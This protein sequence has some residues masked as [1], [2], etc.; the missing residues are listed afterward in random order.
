MNIQVETQ[1]NCLTTVRIEL[2]PEKVTQKIDTITRDYHR[3]ARIPGF[4]PGKAPRPV[5]EQR[6]RKEI[7][8]ELERQLI[9]EG[10]REAIKEQ[11]LRVV[12]VADVQN[13]A[14]GPDQSFRFTVILYTQPEF[15]LPDYQNI[16][17]TLPPL[18]VTETEVDEA[19]EHLRNR[20]AEFAD[21]PSRAVQIDDYAVIDYT[22]TIDGQPVSEVAPKGGRLLA[23]GQDFWIRLTEGAFLPGFS[24]A[25]VGLSPGES[26][27]FAIDLPADFPAEELRGRRID[28]QV[29]LKAVKQKSLPALDDQFAERVV[30]GK[31]LAELRTMVRSDLETE[32]ASQAEREKRTQIMNHLN[33]KVECEVPPNLMRTETRRIL[34]D[35][36]RE[37]QVRGV[38]ED[39]LKENEKELV[40]AA[41]QGAKERLKGAFILLRIAEKEGIKVTAEEFRDRVATLAG[42]YQMTPEKMLKEIEKRDIAGQIEEE[43]LTGKV[44]D[45]LASRVSVQPTAAEP[46]A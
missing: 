30:Q 26:R 46:A 32:K 34:A 14:L 33:G 40:G 21:I 37:N 7:R 12:S 31:T 29:T 24:A 3:H 36:V 42:H 25:L 13:V 8:E 27:S 6:F 1:P 41:M 5:I 44:L 17:L 4:R 39:L 23:S 45:F 43:I 28:Y 9:G 2:P 18:E 16:P 19:I 11:N 38:A 10:C 22:G 35:I 20:H 15:E